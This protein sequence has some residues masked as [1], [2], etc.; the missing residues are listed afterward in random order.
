[1]QS[2]EVIRVVE[3]AADNEKLEKMREKLNV[4]IPDQWEE[5]K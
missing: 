4:D 5:N 3:N 2:V 1:V